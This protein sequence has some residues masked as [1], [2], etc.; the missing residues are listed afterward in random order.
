MCHVIP[1]LTTIAKHCGAPRLLA[2]TRLRAF[3][4]G[5]VPIV[6]HGNRAKHNDDTSESVQSIG[7][8]KTT[9]WFG[10]SVVVLE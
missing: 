10:T 1:L 7:G 4:E 8:A 5:V 3:H 6:V 2:L 9:T